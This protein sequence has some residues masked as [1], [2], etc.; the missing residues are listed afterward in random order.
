MWWQSTG[1]VLLAG[2]A[3]VAGG[4]AF[5]RGWRDSRERRERQELLTRLAAGM[6]AEAARRASGR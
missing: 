1:V 5:T 2:M 4:R 3:V 6:R